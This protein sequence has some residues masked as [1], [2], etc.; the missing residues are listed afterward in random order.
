MNLQRRDL[1][2]LNIGDRFN[3]YYCAYANSVSRYFQRV[4]AETE[5]M[6]CPIRMKA[7]QGFTEHQ[8]HAGFVDRADKRTLEAYYVEFEGGL[9]RG[10]GARNAAD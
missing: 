1:S 4:V 10:E 2:A 7:R 3:C 8:H 5:R 9:A 6:W